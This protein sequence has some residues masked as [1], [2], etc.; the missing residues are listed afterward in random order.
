LPAGIDV[1]AGQ[2]GAGDEGTAMLQ[3]VHQIAP[4]AALGF[5]TGFNGS[6]QMAL[7]IQTLRN[8]PHNCTIIVDDVTYF[9]EAAFQEGNIA[10]AVTTVTAAG[11]LYYSSAAN[12]GSFV[13]GTS[14][15]WQGDFVNGGAVGAPITG[16]ES[17]TVHA[18]AMGTN[19][20]TLTSQG[21]A[22][23]EI[24]NWSDPFGASSNDYDFFALDAAG[25]TLLA[26]STN[27]QTGTQNPQEH[28]PNPTNS[29]APT[30]PTNA[31]LVVVNYQNLAAPRALRVDTQRGRLA[32]ATNG[33]TYGHNGGVNTVSVAAVPTSAASGAKFT[34]ADGV[35]TYSSD[36]PRKLFYT[37]AGA[38]ITPGNVL[39]ATGGGTTLQ[40][41]DISAAD[42]SATNVV[43]FFTF[44][45]TSAAAPHAAAI[46]ALIKSAK[47]SLTPAQIKAAMNA[48]AL[49]NE[50]PGFDFNA[51]NGITM[52][53]AAVR[54]V[55]SPLTVGKSFSPSS[56]ATNA[57]S[58][59]TITI[60]NANTVALNGVAFTDSYPVNLKN[61]AAPAAS[62]TP[63]GC[64]GTL[65]AVA[66]GTSFAL[67][68]GV[69]PAGATCSYKVNV[70][71]AVNGTYV[72]SSG[73]ITTPIALNTAAVGATLTV[74][75]V[76]AAA[77]KSD[78][79][80]DG[81]SDILFE[82]GASRWFDYMNGVAVSSSVPAPGVAPGWVF[83]GVGDFNGDGKA[84]ILWKNAGSPN[85]TWI[86]LLNGN[87]VIGGGGITA[88]PGYAPVFVADFDGNGKS[89]IVFANAG[90]SRWVYRMNGA[91]VA[92]TLALPGAAPGWTLAGAAD[93]SGDGR[94]DLLWRNGAAPTQYWIY[95]LNGAAI[96]GGGGITV[97][98]GYTMTRIGD[99]N[100]DARADLLFENA[101][102]ARWFYYMSGAAVAGTVGVPAA[103][104]GWSIVG[105][106]DFNGDG[107][108]DL[109]WRNG[110]APTQ[111]W[112]YLLN[113]NVV[114]G[115]G[116]FLVAPGYSAQLPIN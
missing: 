82:N 30:L 59:L 47:A 35:E 107:K 81:R 62:I 73:T 99:F 111:H 32:I 50:A 95:V 66:G 56:I 33:N 97:A 113:G 116:G 24:L 21:S 109:L 57:T 98:A 92:S 14:G 23:W 64:T 52:A 11:A 94:A 93:F 103:A 108:T 114:T 22:Q 54:S 48:T 8:P 86:H 67:A 41:V 2:E 4:G 6:A 61:A 58:Q 106:A 70:T 20:N 15:T 1:V 112:I 46:A 13:K 68:N 89:D 45:G 110:A 65:T 31:R 71:S 37:P 72:N 7:N 74:S 87:A 78:F 3:I 91:A 10:Q 79:N 69:V 83:A 49:D 75:S 96:S 12:S 77:K 40:K 28:F 26:Q 102:G 19:Y 29:P 5:A 60:A 105:T 80:G 25:T 115:S 63:G 104:P 88:A 16:V 51:G 76:V 27:F 44:C 9:L 34:T 43:G 42:C 84:D 53:D 101:A 36:G 18:F 17:G 85:Q 90:G 39:F 38:A 100:G 55:L